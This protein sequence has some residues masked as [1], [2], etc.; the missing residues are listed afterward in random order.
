MKWYRFKS[1][2]RMQAPNLM[3][4]AKHDMPLGAGRKGNKTPRKKS[5][6]PKQV[7]TDENRVPLQLESSTKIHGNTQ[8]ITNN[9]KSSQLPLRAT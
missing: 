7:L 2:R 3:Q 8:A 9:N 6:R 1:T 5:L 4:L